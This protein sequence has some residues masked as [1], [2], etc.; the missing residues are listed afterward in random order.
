MDADKSFAGLHP[1]AVVPS[2]Q[3]R[4][5]VANDGGRVV[6]GKTEM[7]PDPFPV[8]SVLVG[9]AWR[10]A[11]TPDV[12]ILTDQRVLAFECGGDERPAMP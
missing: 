1:G 6:T 5:P 3:T 11:V 9:L 12:T 4:I 2:D 8:A 7:E 10:R